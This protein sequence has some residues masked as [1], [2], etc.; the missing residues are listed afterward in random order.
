[1]RKTYM[2]VTSGILNKTN[3]LCDKLY[4][5]E[6]ELR[7]I[8][9]S[10]GNSQR[11]PKSDESLC[12]S[13]LGALILSMD[14]FHHWTCLAHTWGESSNWA[15]AAPNIQQIHFEHITEKE[16]FDQVQ[17]SRTFK[18]MVDQKY[19]EWVSE[20]IG[21]S[22]NKGESYL[23]YDKRLRDQ[24]WLMEQPLGME[25]FICIK[26]FSCFLKT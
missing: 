23:Q 3:E 7:K 15:A 26:L 2:E 1:M 10:G 13:Y 11:P 19:N 20:Y 12:P 5:E 8:S 24:P 9:N 22:R 4:K 14:E 25:N 18:D 16:L 21:V 6:R 17:E